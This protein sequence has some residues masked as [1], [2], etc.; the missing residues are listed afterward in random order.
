LTQAQWLFKK[1]PGGW[2]HAVCRL[3]SVL[4]AHFRLPSFPQL[5]AVRASAI[6]SVPA[7]AGSFSTRSFRKVDLEQQV[8]RVT[9]ENADA[10]SL[11]AEMPRHFI[12]IAKG[13]HERHISLFI[14]FSI[15]RDKENGQ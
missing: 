3:E 9:L 10:T 11:K 15:W 6:F 5:P 7:Q 12:F 14:L 13:H 8:T 4:S 2:P 1:Q